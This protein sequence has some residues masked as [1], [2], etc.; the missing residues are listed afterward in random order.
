MMR[1]CWWTVSADRGEGDDEPMPEK[2]HAARASAVCE[3]Q[4]PSAAMTAL[5]T[6]TLN[7]RM[8][9]P[10]VTCAACLRLRVDGERKVRE[11]GLMEWCPVEEKV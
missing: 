11:F 4:T 8:W 6:E 5:E 3:L 9:R 2:P 10:P 7:L 1:T